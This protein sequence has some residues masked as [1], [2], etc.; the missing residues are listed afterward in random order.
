MFIVKINKKIKKFN[1][2]ITGVDLLQEI[3][4]KL[5][6]ECI[7]IKI[8]EKIQDLSIKI[9]YDCKAT[10][11]F[12]SS[13]EESLD[14]IRYNAA[15]ILAQAVKSLFPKAMTVTGNIMKDGFYY[16][17]ANIQS[18]KA[19]NLK[20]IETKM[21]EIIDQ[22]LPINK[23]FVSKKEAINLF[24]TQGEKYKVA[25]IQS[26]MEEEPVSIYSQ[27]DFL[28]LYQGLHIS[29]TGFIKAFK[30]TKVSAVHWS[31]HDNHEMLQ[32]I[33]GTAWS[34]KKE[35]DQ[36]LTL[37][38][39][40]YK[41]DHR[42]IGK[43][44]RLFHLQEESPGSIFW[45]PKGWDLFQ[46]LITFIRNKQ[47]NNG[48]QEINTP[49]IMNKKL[50]ESSGHWEK[51]RTNMFTIN[52]ANQDISYAIRPMSCPG[53][54]QVYNQGIKSY[55]DLPVR[56]SEFGKVHRFEPSGSLYGLMRA[57]SFT[58]DD[59]HIFCTNEQITSECI[60]VCTLIKE[61]YQD[62]GFKNIKVK[63]SDRPKRRIGSNEVW[64]KS[65]LAL[66]HAITQEKIPY[67]LNQGEG[68]FY[69]PK[70]E[71]VLKDAIGR[72]WQLG[73]L[74]VDFN[75]P[76]RLNA[77]YTGKDG[78][79]H[80]V[81]I[82]H[83]ALFGSIERFIGILLE[84]YSGNL[85]IWLAPIQIVIMSVTNGVMDYAKYVCHILEKNS[86]RYITDF[87]NQ[88]ISYKI[89]KHSVDKIPIIVILGKKEEKNKLVSIRKL[90]DTHQE[91]LELTRFVDIITNDIQQKKR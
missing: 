77:L 57:R 26:F 11:I 18:F 36:Y 23:K 17:F 30:L 69:G 13:T 51:F 87:D 88:K 37:L 74:Q 27:E 19:I 47:K 33:C 62:F 82:L 80:R 56:F 54:V 4:E 81:V 70:I 22:K 40:M 16:D 91:T 53:S 60:K 58:Q 3:D 46:R 67:T 24:Y 65:E 63:F 72:D 85:P 90:G 43:Q 50:W 5:R 9:N 61:I 86:I 68:A 41:R 6:N 76:D 42:K 7:A 32:R 12:S 75:L 44:S 48:Y 52:T 79:Q 89:R 73:T 78:R 55:R 71:F 10:F 31:K 15:H 66:L 28:D 39:E 49:E 35:L 59:A 20:T 45:H 84:H 64:D 38:E 8:N 29:H 2:T 21:Q 34:N 1:E 14:I 25:I 83:R